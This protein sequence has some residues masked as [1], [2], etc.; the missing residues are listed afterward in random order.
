MSRVK[1]PLLEG[2]N[3]EVG[4]PEGLADASNNDC[5]GL[6]GASLFGRRALFS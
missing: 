5:R 2:V 4:D 3:L 1:D 6:L